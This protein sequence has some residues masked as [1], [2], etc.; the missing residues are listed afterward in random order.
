MLQRWTEGLWDKGTGGGR[1]NYKILMTELRLNGNFLNWF[2]RGAQTETAWGDIEMRR[3]SEL[4][5]PSLSLWT[6]SSPLHLWPDM[7]FYPT[8]EL[9]PHTF[10]LLF[11]SLLL[12]LNFSSPSTS[13][14]CSRSPYDVIFLLTIISF[15]STMVCVQVLKLQVSNFNVVWT[16]SVI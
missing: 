8:L 10:V 12:N 1:W 3:A 6:C 14:C 11:Q 15:F 4:I 16:D 5:P 9:H 13:V 2:W 7:P